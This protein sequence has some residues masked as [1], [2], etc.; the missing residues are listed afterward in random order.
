MLP[1]IAGRTTTGTG[2]T[3]LDSAIREAIDRA[4]ARDPAARER[5]YR[6]A[7]QALERGLARRPDLDQATIDE[8]RRR[9]D[10]LIREIESERVAEEDTAGAQ[11]EARLSAAEEW[12]DPFAA[13]PL[14]PPVAEEPPFAEE[15]DR[16]SFAAGSVSKPHEPAAWPE[17]EELR[18]ENGVS[19]A[20][21]PAAR[22]PGQADDP[23]HHSGDMFDRLAE[24]V[25]AE[26]RPT[27]KER[28]AAGKQERRRARK[29]RRRPGTAARLMSALFLLVS[30][31][32]FGALALWLL[33]ATGLVGGTITA[34]GGA[35]S[36]RKF[37]A[38]SNGGTSNLMTEDSF[39][40]AW[41]PIFVPG[42]G[43]R[44]IPGPAAGVEK[45]SDERGKALRLTSTT[46]GPDG[47]LR[48]EVPAAVMDSM[49]GRTS[50]LALNMRAVDGKPTEIA[51]ECAFSSLGGCSRRRFHVAAEMT[52]VVM[53]LV[54]EKGTPPHRPGYLLLNTDIAG[55]GRP[56][57]LFAVGL[58]GGS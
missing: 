4:E 38:V 13:E 9:F 5:V 54:F 15:E 39:G 20:P 44:I 46:S 3:G 28:K 56:V 22:G 40:G 26:R 48:I 32:V 17:Q 53:K 55:K 52:D 45:V 57:D 14:E 8:Q 21:A 34:G 1:G 51:I 27:R 30:L 35:S 24:E 43:D 47:Y 23:V 33:N 2:V 50:I 42:K 58:R 29:E 18:A 19:P 41:S 37:D 12:T 31:L 16:S 11:P 25:R 6:S 36:F 49:A 7:R 10:E